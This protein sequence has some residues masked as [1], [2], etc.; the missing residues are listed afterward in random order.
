MVCLQLVR[1][2]GNKSST[3]RVKPVLGQKMI[4]MPLK[5]IM[6]QFMA[7]TESLEPIAWDVRSIQYAKR[8]AVP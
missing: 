4:N 8:I 7:Y 1:I 2:S 3:G 6:P 5:K